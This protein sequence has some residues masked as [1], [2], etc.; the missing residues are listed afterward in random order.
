MHEPVTPGNS[1]AVRD[2]RDTMQRWTRAAAAGAL[3]L[4]VTIFLPAAPALAHTSLRASTPA[5]NSSVHMPINFVQLTF[6]SAP[7]QPSVTVTG[8]DGKNLSKGTAQVDG[9]VVKQP[10]DTLPSGA[11]TVKWRVVSPDGD[12]V[13]GTFKFTN[14][15]T[16]A[17]PEPSKPPAGESTQRPS[18]GPATTTDPATATTSAT[19]TTAPV[20][21][22]PRSADDG[23]VSPLWWVGAVLVLLAAIG[24]GALWYRRRRA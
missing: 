2:D 23:G 4:V 7:T 16:G 3:G 5:A 14:A 21:A 10:L 18:T 13:E 20:D 22:A 8:T 24:G 17:A 12:P 19:A 11:I 9:V 1:A 6:S 15:V